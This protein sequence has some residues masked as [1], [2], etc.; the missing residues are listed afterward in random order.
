MSESFVYRMLKKTFDDNCGTDK[1][2]GIHFCFQCGK[3]FRID[4]AKYCPDCN[5][6]IAP[7][8]HCG[9]TLSIDERID[10]ELAFKRICGG[11]CRLNPKKRKKR[12]LVRISSTDF[13]KWAEQYYPSLVS[14]YRA[15]K[16]SLDDLLMRIYERIGLKFH[17]T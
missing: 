15:G 13:F 8:G 14:D 1:P 17:I 6:W 11:V 12:N 2:T 10:L 4:E 7:C 9:C 16:I 3:P 5:W